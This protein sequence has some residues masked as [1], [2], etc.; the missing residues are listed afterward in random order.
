MIYLDDY[1]NKIIIIKYKD[2]IKVLVNLNLDKFL[3]KNIILN[4]VLLNKIK[5]IIIRKNSIINNNNKIFLI[6][7]FINILKLD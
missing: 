5:D 3:K 4:I 1:F 2:K 6:N 7:I